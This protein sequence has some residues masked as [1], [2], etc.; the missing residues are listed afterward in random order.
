MRTPHDHFADVL[1]HCLSR[2]SYRVT[3][4][5][6][7]KLSGV[8]K[9][10][11]VNW[12]EGRV[13]HPRRWQDVV[14]V[15]DA[16]RLDAE[17]TERL[18]SAGGHP[19]LAEL[20]ATPGSEDEELLGSWLRSATPVRSR[21]VAPGLVHPTTPLIGRDAEVSSVADL[22]RRPDVRFLTLTGPPGVGKTRIAL[23]V[24]E[25]VHGDFHHGVAFVSLAPVSD[26][27]KVGQAIATAVG[28]SA[29]GDELVLDRLRAAL[30]SRAM[31]LVLDN[32]EHLAEATGGIGMMLEDT[33]E[34][35]VLATSRAVLH[36]YG[37]HQFSVPP[38]P[39]PDPAATSDAGRLGENDAVALF[40]ARARAVDPSFR[41]TSRNAASVASIV[42]R[43][44]G[45]PLSIELAAARSKLLTPRRLL[46]RL[47]NRLGLLTWGARDR[48][49]RH[50][51]LRAMLDWSFRQLDSSAMSL[52]MR[53]AVFAGGCTI[54]SAAAV[55]NGG[56]SNGETVT[57]ALMRLVDH[58]LMFKL[59]GRGGDWRFTMLATVRE[60]AAEQAR[61]RG[62]LDPARHRFL[63]HILEVAEAAEREMVAPDQRIWLDRLDDERD[64]VRAALTE[65]LQ[66]HDNVTAARLAAALSRLWLSR[67]YIAEGRRWLRQ[68]LEC[69]ELPPAV[70]TKARL[71]AGR[72]ARRQG[73][74]ATADTELRRAIRSS[75][76]EGDRV[77]EAVALEGL[78]LVA[79]D[80][81]DL[82]TADGLLSASHEQCR[83]VGDPR[84]IAQT[85]SD[86]G[87]V[88]RRRGDTGAA[89]ARQDAALATFREL[90]DLHSVAHVLTRMGRAWFDREVHDRAHENLV[91]ALSV[92]LSLDERVDVVECVEALAANALASA[93]WD[94]AARLSGAAR[95]I[96]W[97]SGVVATPAERVRQ[98]QQ[99]R[100]ICRQLGDDALEQ[101]LRE[102]AE[103]TLGQLGRE[104]G[105]TPS[106]ERAPFGRAGDFRSVQEAEA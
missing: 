49:D 54:D 7:G 14:R 106:P 74:L 17:D 64:N 98:A 39:L 65:A 68:V 30:R 69:Q 8:P 29:N 38:L 10:T 40:V 55:A 97:T 83:L 11:I 70:A 75:V 33:P 47:G 91:E 58:S 95:R 44:D 102:G 20:A 1:R 99:L 67:S 3:P 5:L 94:Q 26:W 81:S 18:L 56:S 66:Q 45:L 27:R 19:G 85:L 31:L 86:L 4:G 51:S 63:A 37:E 16:L 2:P 103:A 105:A 32:V 22:I 78:G 42:T 80:R 100:H 50:Q 34:V 96:R 12:L 59:A 62:E 36:V 13:T 84:G 101:A 82:R 57:D 9:A 104:L 87:E 6:L 53:L 41:L 61:Q 52:F 73:D 88:D 35:R 89:I 43:L 79:L 92:W 77:S 48:P 21:P 90:H 76:V 71:V 93:R 24:A 25:S 60:Y 72:L 28:L 46:D 23:Q 15:A